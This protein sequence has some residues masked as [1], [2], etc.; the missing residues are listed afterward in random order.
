MVIRR[1]VLHITHF[2]VFHYLQDGPAVAIRKTV[3]YIM[4]FGVF[5][6]FTGR[7]GVFHY[8]QDGP[9]Y[10]SCGYMQD[11]LAYNISL[12]NTH[13]IIMFKRA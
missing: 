13:L 5:S 8:L 4:H 9:A 10:N 6:L 2:G 12:N 1:L 3:L 11:C 7:S